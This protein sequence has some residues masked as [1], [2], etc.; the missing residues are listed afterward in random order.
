MHILSERLKLA[1]NK[2]KKCHDKVA[3]VAHWELCSKYGFES[4]KH[5][6]EHRTEGV[7]EN[8]NTKIL[9]N[10]NIRNDCAIEAR[11][12]DIVLTDK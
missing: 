4:P 12:P 8:Q 11:H 10:F 3:T 6:Y 9:W 1:Q 5:W 7:V 2:Y